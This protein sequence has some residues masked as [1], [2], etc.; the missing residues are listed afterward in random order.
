MDKIKRCWNSNQSDG[1]RLKTFLFHPR[2]KVYPNF[3]QTREILKM[4]EKNNATDKYAKKMLLEMADR[5]L[6]I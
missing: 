1:I 3:I 4:E 2:S 6:L 5:L